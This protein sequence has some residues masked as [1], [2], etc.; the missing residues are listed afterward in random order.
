MAKSINQTLLMG[1]LTNDVE[2][3]TTTSGKQVVSFSLA[4]DKPGKDAGTDFFEVT[5]WEKLAELLTKYVSKGSKVLVQ[6]RLS[7]ETWED[8]TTNKKRSKVTIV[9]SD[10]TFLDSPTNQQDSQA[11][12]DDDMSKPVDLAEIPF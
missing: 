6:G 12:Q 5:A 4:V 7:Q 9:A 3:R 1:R 8:K 10:V 11:K 2:A